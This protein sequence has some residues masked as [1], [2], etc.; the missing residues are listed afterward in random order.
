M[1]QMSVGTPS[2]QTFLDTLSEESRNSILELGTTR[3]FIAGEILFEEGAPIHEVHVIVKGQVKLSKQTAEGKIFTLFLKQN[4]DLISEGMLFDDT[5]S[6]MTAEAVTAS[7]ISVLPIQEMRNLFLQDQQLAIA[8]MSWCS[9]QT[10]ST[11][12]KFR[13]LILSGKQGALYSTLIRFAHSYGQE[14]KQGILIKTPLTHQ[15]LADYSGS[16][17]ENVNRMITDLK[18]KGILT[19]EKSRILIH[20]LDYMKEILHC[21]SCPI[22]ICTM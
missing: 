5:P 22:D 2:V 6:P 4:G 9:I 13:D 10:Q 15:D 1:N 16:T 18:K 19:M 14:T 7:E 20:D 8:L 21:W 3:K 12:A 17:R 11:Q